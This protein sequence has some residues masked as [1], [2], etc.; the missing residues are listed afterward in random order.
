[1]QYIYIT[2]YSL[3]PDRNVCFFCRQK[4][5]AVRKDYIECNLFEIRTLPTTITNIRYY[6]NEQK[7]CIVS[8][9]L[10]EYEKADQGILSTYIP[11]ITVKFCSAEEYVS[12]GTKL[13]VE[14]VPELTSMA[15]L[16]FRIAN[17]PPLPNSSCSSELLQSDS[18]GRHHGILLLATL[19]AK[20]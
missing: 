19:S 10:C 17:A 11:V 15:Y 2:I 1:M 14:F 13:E 9:N 16:P 8:R 12:L 3:V 6:D 5:P 20:Q 18:I 7:K 4:T